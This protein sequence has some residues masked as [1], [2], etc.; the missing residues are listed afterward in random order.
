MN[1]VWWDCEKLDCTYTVLICGY[2][3]CRLECKI[4]CII[5]STL[6]RIY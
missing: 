5:S 4:M 2:D 1:S 6:L 3:Y